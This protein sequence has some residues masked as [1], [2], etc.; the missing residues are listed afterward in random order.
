MENS[1]QVRYPFLSNKKKLV[2]HIKSETLFYK[3]HGNPFPVSYCAT[4]HVST[5]LLC[6][7]P[8]R[9]VS[10]VVRMHPPPS[11]ITSSHLR[12]ARKRKPGLHFQKCSFVHSATLLHANHEG[13]ELGK[14]WIR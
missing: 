11:T 4:R 8:T 10:T 3:S 7:K 12:G 6:Y 1:I 9:H 2:N 5:K 14:S 13:K